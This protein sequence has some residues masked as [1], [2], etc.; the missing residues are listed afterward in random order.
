MKGNRIQKRT[1]SGISII[2]FL[3]ASCA[4]VAVKTDLAFGPSETRWVVKTLKQMTL[5]EKVGQLIACRYTGDF[6]NEESPYL[7]NLKDLVVN[8]RSEG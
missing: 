1:L 3:S 5:E 4:P 8:R 7:A 6:F 2:V